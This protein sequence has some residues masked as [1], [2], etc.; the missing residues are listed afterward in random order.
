MHVAGKKHQRQREGTSQAVQARLHGD[1]PG[2]VA[3]A[4]RLHGDAPGCAAQRARRVA[5]LEAGVTAATDGVLSSA[6]AVPTAR[7][8]ARGG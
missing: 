3:K 5:L 1:A 6:G 2:R 4:L 8:G 7:G